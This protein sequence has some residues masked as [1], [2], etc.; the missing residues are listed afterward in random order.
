M[1][2]VKMHTTIKASYGDKEALHK[3]NKKGY[4]LDKDLSNDNEQVY[5]KHKKHGGKKLLYTV[6]GTHNLKDVGT[7]LYLAAGKLKNT[8]RYK[9]ADDILQSTIFD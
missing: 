8:K 4:V 7:D 9:E 3:L 6:A 1:G 2:K 5:Y